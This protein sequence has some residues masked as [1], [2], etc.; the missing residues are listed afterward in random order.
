ME[1]TDVQA[2][3]VS[4]PGGAEQ[5]E[6]SRMRAIVQYRYGGPEVL[7]LRDI[8][9][10]TIGDEEVLVRVV[11]A[12]VNRAAWHLMTGVPYLMRVM[13]FGLR[14]PKVAV[15]GTNLAGRVVEVGTS[16]T[17]L[18]PGDEVY[19]A[20]VGTFAEYAC[21]HQNKLARMPAGLSYEQ[22]AGVPHGG[23]TALQALRDHGKVQSGQH[24]LIVGASGA[25]GSMAVPLAKAFGATVTGV[26]STAKIDLVR[27]LGADHVIDYLT[28][29]IDLG[30]ERYDVI[31]DIGGNRSIAHLRRALSARG[32]LVIVGGEGGGR[33]TYGLHRQL[34]AL[35]LSPFSRQ[36]LTTFIAREHR[37]DLIALNGFIEAGAVTPV[38]DQVF[39]LAEAREAFR[40]LERGTARGRLALS[41]R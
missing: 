2:A 25:V 37:E 14:S 8:E 34:G 23:L 24:V 20:G 11:A 17:D 5:P 18:A 26:C 41:V 7:E 40:V 22:A 38:V 21:A 36:K 16:V 4:A 3:E 15:A 10:P 29:D 6:S 31:L 32:T 35:V 12:D 1:T 9:R 19:G 13:G 33:W 39:S 28:S 30:A 27:S